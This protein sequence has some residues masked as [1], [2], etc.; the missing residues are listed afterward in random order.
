MN[1]KVTYTVEVSTPI[2]DAPLDDDMPNYMDDVVSQEAWQ[3]LT[4]HQVF[5]EDIQPA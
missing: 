3:M 1:W 4:V 5:T 2:E